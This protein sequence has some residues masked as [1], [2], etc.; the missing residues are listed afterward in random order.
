M[1]GAAAWFVTVT[2]R[3]LPFGGDW[4]VIQPAGSPGSIPLGWVLRGGSNDSG[5]LSRAVLVALQLVGGGNVQVA[6]AVSVTVVVGLAAALILAAGHRRGHTAYADA[7]FPVVLLHLGHGSVFSW[8]WQVT[9]VMP[10]ALAGCLLVIAIRYRNF[11]RLGP[12]VMA[13]AFLMLLALVGRTGPLLIPALALWYAGLG[14]H[15]ILD[16]SKP[17]RSRLAGW[18]LV[19]AAVGAAVAWFVTF[20]ASLVNG[21]TLPSGGA[22]ELAAGL[23]MA[24]IG[25]GPAADRSWWSSSLAMASLALTVPLAAGIGLLRPRGVGRP[26]LT[27]P[28]FVAALFVSLFALGWGWP[29]R[30]GIGRDP[31]AS[32]QFSLLSTLLACGVYA[33]WAFEGP[34]ALRKIGPTALLGFWLV[35]APVNTAEGLRWR[36]R[37]RYGMFAV[38]RDLSLADPPTA[39]DLATRHSGFLAADLTA[40]DLASRMAALRGRGAFSRLPADGPARRGNGA[41]PEWTSAAPLVTL[42]IT[43][44][45]PEAG[46]VL[47]GWGVFGWAPSPAALRPPGT[48]VDRTMRSPMIEH[49]GTFSIDVR[50]PVGAAVDYGFL[51]TTRRDGRPIATVWDG[52]YRAIARP[53]GVA[54]VEAGPKLV[55]QIAPVVADPRPTVRMRYRFPAAGEVDLVWGHGAGR[56]PIRTDGP[57]GTVVEDGRLVTPMQ[58]N[59]AEFISD[60]RVRPGTTV[61]YSFRTRVSRTGEVIAPLWDRS[62]IYRL[63]VERDTVVA[64]TAAVG[65]DETRPRSLV[66]LGVGLLIAGVGAGLA[67][68]A[69]WPTRAEAALSTSG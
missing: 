36:D 34:T 46:Q 32:E 63:E 17:D 33:F 23:R 18:G 29:V 47:L 54:S 58:Q 42:R 3:S 28:V 59:G 49:E 57:M 35:L 56:P 60:L 11:A 68:R 20:R 22:A 53:Q 31:T 10:T 51:V 55:S 13:G 8:A 12:A 21:L 50:V 14:V 52:N 37:Y 5:P 43:Y 40:S 2:A 27:V 26:L 65:I 24:A 25:L 41:L 44:H 69:L 1:A 67:L 30:T 45:F 7:F 64:V 9:Q 66:V 15:Q 39:L 4:L 62:P 61:E 19:A 6:M 48:V 16:S 38:E